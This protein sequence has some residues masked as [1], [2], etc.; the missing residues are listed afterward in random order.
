MIFTLQL[1]LFFLASLNAEELD[2]FLK[3]SLRT[4]LCPYSHFCTSNASEIL[5]EEDH[6]SCCIPCSCADDCWRRGNCCPD[7]RILDSRP[8]TE[9][10]LSTLVKRKADDNSNYNGIHRN[11]KR[12]FVVNSCLNTEK[13]VTI[14]EKCKGNKKTT[15]EDYA[16]VSDGTKIYQ[17]KYCAECNGI[18]EYTMWNLMTTCEELLS[19]IPTAENNYTIPDSCDIINYPSEGDDFLT[20]MCYDSDISECNTT[21][22]WESYDEKIHAACNAFNL[23]FL[24]ISYF[25]IRVYRNVFCYLCNKKTSLQT[26]GICSV[27]GLGVR[28]NLPPFW[29]IFDWNV[30]RHRDL[31][32]REMVTCA[33]NK[34]ADPY[35]VTKGFKNISLEK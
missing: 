7:K 14:A 20:S 32:Q 12:Y 3:V 22:L 16:W 13:N 11:I 15:L 19:S 28:D 31:Q 17:N 5:S 8:P 25:K 34:F 18:S 2:E 24:Q 27:A 26:E 33:V 9:E 4:S 6:M 23:T 10:C 35:T 1:W 21:G 29:A 30:Y